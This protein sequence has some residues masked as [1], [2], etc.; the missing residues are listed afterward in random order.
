MSSN[1]GRVD[2]RK[3]YSIMY[4]ASKYKNG[5]QLTK[6]EFTN[7]ITYLTDL[8]TGELA[9]SALNMAKRTH[10]EIKNY[11]GDTSLEQYV[12]PFVNRYRSLMKEI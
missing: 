7:F 3:G 9:M 5:Q 12:T 6:D 8:N 4:L 11:L 1:T 10:P 2:L